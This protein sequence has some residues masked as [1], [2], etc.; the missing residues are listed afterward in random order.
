MDKNTEALKDT[1]PGQA[2]RILKRLGAQ[3]G[4]CTDNNTFKLPGHCTE[5][6]TNQES[7]ERIASYFS[8]ISQEYSPLDTHKLPNRVR[9]KLETSS[10]PP[11]ITVQETLKMNYKNIVLNAY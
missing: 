5:N 7:A 2:Y 9:R 8:A 3:P 10:S 4:D 11:I 1:N 6:L